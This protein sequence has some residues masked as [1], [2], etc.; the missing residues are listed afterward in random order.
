MLTAFDYATLYDDETLCPSFE[1]I[2]TCQ[3]EADEGF[4]AVLTDCVANDIFEGET[5]VSTEK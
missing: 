4:A 5:C 1:L 3:A 2:E